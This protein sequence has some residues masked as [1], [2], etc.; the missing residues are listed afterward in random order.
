[1]IEHKINIPISGRAYDILIGNGFYRDGVDGGIAPL[2]DGRSCLVISD[3][4][5][6][7]LYGEHMKD[8]LTGAGAAKVAIT[9]FPAGEESK[10]LETISGFYHTAVAAGMDRRSL[11]IALGGGV[12]GDMAGFTAATFMRGIEY[13]QCPTS[14]LAMVDSAV[15]GK[16]G[17]DL[18][19]GK[20][21]V[22]AFKQPKAVLADVATLRTLPLREL[23]CGLAEVVKYGVIQDA[24][25]FAFLAAS[26]EGLLQLDPAIYS[27]V[28][29]RCCELKAEVVLAD[30]ED[31]TG[32]RAILNYGHTFGHALEKLADFSRLN[33]GEAVAIGMMMAADL[34]SRRQPALEELYAQQESLWQRLGLQTRAKGF[35]PQE[36]LAAMRTDKKYEHGQVRVILPE[37]LG[38]CV[39]VKD[40]TEDELLVSIEAHCDA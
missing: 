27:R 30:E 32:Q 21:L 35:N 10:T 13:L 23:R 4:N 1:M 40:V 37:A 31:L 36:V 5:V 38:R 33:H 29:Q 24:D 12:T 9:T 26:V 19:E 17:V 28:I 15:G 25:F 6:A 16:T 7:P 14:L 34:A 20:N 8:L 39:V 11:I 2:I 18:P 22:G 3:S